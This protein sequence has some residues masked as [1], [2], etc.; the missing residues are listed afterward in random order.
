MQRI[1]KFIQR[2]SFNLFC[3]L[4][5]SISITL[6]VL[7]QSYQA[8]SIISSANYISAN[9]YEKYDNMRTYFFLKEENEHLAQQNK[10]LIQYIKRGL[11]S[12][13]SNK[14]IQ[15]TIYKQAYEYIYSKA[16]YN[17]TNKRN[18]FLTLNSGYTKGVGKDM[19]VINDFGIVGIIKDVSSNFASVMSILHKD[20]VINCKLKREGSNG[21][22]SWEGDN[23]QICNL[24]DIPTHVNIYK[25]DTVIT[26]N[27]SHIFPEGIVV[28]TVEDVF[29]NEQSLVYTVKIK[30]SADMNKVDRVTIIKSL[31]KDEMQKLEASSQ[32]IK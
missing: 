20:V 22:L 27:L 26:S 10:Y 12:Y 14:T 13:P 18:N 29:T 19:G 2:Y 31:Y 28:G 16:V 32:V 7:S 9:V 6:I 11:Y 25:G 17:T 24:N 30:L 5:I 15:D 1:L 8:V 4:Y 23:Y 3:L 21:T